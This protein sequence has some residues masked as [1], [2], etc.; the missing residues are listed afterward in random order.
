VFRLIQRHSSLIVSLLFVGG[1]TFIF[2][3]LLERQHNPNQSNLVRVLDTGEQEVVLEQNRSGHYVASGEINGRPVLL[4][5]DTGATHVSI[6]AA[7]AAEL[8]L[9]RG[10]EMIAQTANGVVKVYATR[11]ERVRLG[12]IVMENVPASINPGMTGEDILLGMSFL[13][14][15]EMLQSGE[16]LRLRVPPG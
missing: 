15:L 10:S 5:L 4:F 6:P 3:W 13:G 11:L 9:E 12:H 2:A 8:G 7:L 14:R 16:T 1:M